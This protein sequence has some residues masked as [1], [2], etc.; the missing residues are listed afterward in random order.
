MRATEIA[1][2]LAQS[3]ER[4]CLHLLPDGKRKGHE[5]VCGDVDGSAGDSMKVRLTGDKAGV[6]CDFATGDGGDLIG[7]WMQ[8]K[9]LDLPAACK[10]AMDWLGI[11]EA[12]VEN[13]RRQFSRP[14]REGV[15][16]LPPQGAEWVRSVR[17][18]SDAAIKAYCLAFRK[19]A[20]MFPYLRDGELIAAK[21]RAIPEKKFWTDADCEPCLFGWQAIPPNARQLVIVEGEFDA[22]AMF[23]Y[24]FPALSVPFGGGDKAKQQWIEHEFDRL[25]CYDDIVLALDAD[26]AG[27]QAVAEIVKRLGRE[28]VRVA[29]LPRKDANACLIDGVPAEQIAAA[30]R[31]ARSLDPEN[32]KSAA[33]Y[34]DAVWQELSAS[35]GEERGIRL[36]WR[37]EQLILRPGE[38]SIWAGMNGHGKSQ[39]IG[40]VAVSAL[41]R[42]HRC[43]VASLEFIPPKFLRRMQCQHIGK[44]F[45]NESESRM[46]SRE[47]RDKLWVFDPGTKDKTGALLE[48]MAY[49]VRR[50]GVELFVID[51]LA[52]LGI[53][54]DDYSGQA[55]FVDRLTDFTRSYNTH[56]AL[57][58][59]VKKTDKGENSPP[60]KGDVKGSGGITDLVDTV[61]TVWRNKPKEAKVRANKGV[62]TPELAAEPDCILTCHKQRNG[63]AEPVYRLWFDVPSFRYY[64][65]APTLET[66]MAD[67]E[68]HWNEG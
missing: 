68:P 54:E 63:D 56:A 35:K 61:V 11:R 28:R 1:G 7:L 38:T 62:E 32:L 14:A 47:W 60:E 46:L 48:T 41:R 3:V 39:V 64:D 51:N 49:A 31:S 44:R 12:K 10:E 53:A 33:D 25:S 29:T 15:Q 40:H 34:E 36:P 23:D 8:A 30:I 65:E 22:L 52:K 50:Y 42:G 18:I 24:G 66:A 59:H 21:Y 4:V 58:H 2:L 5:W 17:K 9:N 37:K 57:V 43:C 27:K 67:A 13:P 19:G 45:P 20:L 16:A 6:W 55:G 26:E